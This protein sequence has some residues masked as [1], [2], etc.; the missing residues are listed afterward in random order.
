MEKFRSN[1][2]AEETA[3]VKR[4]VFERGE[5]GAVETEKSG[6]ELELASSTGK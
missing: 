2:G 4:M 6:P 3:N 5:R 1:N